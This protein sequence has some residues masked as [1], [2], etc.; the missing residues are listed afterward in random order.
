MGIPPGGTAP[1]YRRFFILMDQLDS[2]IGVGLAAYF[3]FGA[4]FYTA[5]ST[6][7]LFPLVALVVKRILFTL[8][9]KKDYR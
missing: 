2:G 9:L 8:K 3:F 5:L 1:K 6:I 7:A 4:P